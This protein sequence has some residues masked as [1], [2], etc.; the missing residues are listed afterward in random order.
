MKRFIFLLFIVPFLSAAARELPFSNP[1]DTVTFNSILR[2]L[3]ASDLSVGDKL[4]LVAERFV[5]APEDDY[6][7]TDS[8]ACLRLNAGSFSPLMF[9][10]N[11]VALVKASEV[12]GVVDWRTF[13]REFEGIS[14]R[15]GEYAGFPSIM[16][17]TSDW[18]GDNIS[19]GNIT[20][21]TENYAGMV[22]RT[23]SLD[24]MTR[25]RGEF[26]ALADSATFESVRMTEMGFRTHRIPT[27]K[28][29]IVKKKDF[30]DDLRNGDIIILVPGRDGIDCYDIGFVKMEGG[31]PHLIHVSPQ[32]HS[33]VEEKE[34]LARYMQYVTKHFQG[35]RLLRVRD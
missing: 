18:I 28:K 13:S 21:L 16:Y 6:Y 25:K 7:L 35:Y 19:R 4:A 8:V 10:N 27:L 20:E 14:S 23:K 3:K 32:T 11:V 29:E 33:V 26:A 31:V 22:A 2:D 17:H 9:V 12:P 34:D 24:E 5:G 15:R 1:E 30:V